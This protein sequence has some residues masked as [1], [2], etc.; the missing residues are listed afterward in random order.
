MKKIKIAIS[1]LLLALILTGVGCGDFSDQSPKKE[2]KEKDEK[3]SENEEDY[4][5][6]KNKDWDFEIKYPNDWE[7]EIITD[8]HSG[9][10]VAFLSPLKDDKDN[11]QENVVVIAAESKPGDFDE[12][13]QEAIE[14][15]KNYKHEKLVSHSK[16]IISGYSGYELVYIDDYSGGVKKQLHCFINADDVWYQILYTA[17]EGN[18]VEYLAWAEIIINSFKITK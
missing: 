17:D 5:L 18:F 10:A 14:S 15:L 12:L 1:F 7:K 8:E 9:T 13:M 16:K 4:S 11:F 6:Y 3:E 2:G